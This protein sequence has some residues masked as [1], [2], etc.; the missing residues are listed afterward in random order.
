MK[1]LI[2]TLLCSLSLSTFSQ[3]KISGK[4]Q[5]QNDR[6]ELSGA[7]VRLKSTYLATFTDLDGNFSIKNL[8]T[9]T[10]TIVVSY[11]GYQKVE[12]SVYLD[13]DMKINFDLNSTSV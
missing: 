5:Q 9:D 8:P 11:I 13:S 3:H 2:F 7:T 1:G 12:K 4:V 10:Y 6:N